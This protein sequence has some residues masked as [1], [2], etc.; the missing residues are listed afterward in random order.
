MPLGVVMA[1]Q[2]LVGRAFPRLS[3]EGSQ[4]RDDQPSFIKVVKAAQ[5]WID[6]SQIERNAEGEEEPHS[7]DPNLWRIGEAEVDLTPGH[8]YIFGQQ[9]WYLA[10][11]AHERIERGEPIAAQPMNQKA[12][13]SGIRYIPEPPPKEVKE[14]DEEDELALLEDENGPPDLPGIDGLDKDPPAEA[15]T[16][17]SGVTYDGSALCCLAPG[18][19][20]RKSAIKTVEH[21]YFDPIILTTIMANCATMA[22]ESPIDPCCTGKANFIDVCEWIYLF[23]FTF[24]MFS[25]II[26]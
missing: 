16:G 12:R 3:R 4:E 24:E 19:Q 7:D 25:K 26:A 23:I 5:E 21:P 1:L 8:P 13:K 18:D 11:R 9:L 20:P 2:A 10:G 14:L 6:R 17:A 22:W 15:I